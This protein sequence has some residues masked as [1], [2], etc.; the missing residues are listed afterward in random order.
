MV[1]SVRFGTSKKDEGIGHRPIP[2]Q[3]V[4]EQR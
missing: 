1:F 4:R 2:S 3:N